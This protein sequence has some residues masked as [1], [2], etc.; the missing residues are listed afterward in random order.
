MSVLVDPSAYVLKRCVCG[1]QHWLERF[2]KW[3][4]KCDCGEVLTR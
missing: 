2:I 3:T 4:I 1:A